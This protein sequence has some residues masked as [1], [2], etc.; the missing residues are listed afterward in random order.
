MHA[1]PNTF[2]YFIKMCGH[3][4]YKHMP[5]ISLANIYTFIIFSK[6]VQYNERIWNYE[7]IITLFFASNAL[8]CDYIFECNSMRLKFL[9]IYWCYY[10][11]DLLSIIIIFFLRFIFLFL[12]NPHLYL[13]KLCTS[14]AFWKCLCK[15]LVKIYH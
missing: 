1:C 5:L 10:T 15:F 11:L 14:I 3:V 4:Y 7:I 9:I 12:I 6:Y 2:C 8:I 13:S